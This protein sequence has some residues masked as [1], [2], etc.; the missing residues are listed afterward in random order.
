MNVQD[1]EQFADIVE[2]M[3]GAPAF[4]FHDEQDMHAFALALGALGTEVEKQA[5]A[6]AAITSLDQV[7]LY[8]VGKPVPKGR[9][10]LWDQATLKDLTGPPSIGS[11]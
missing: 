3:E 2:A 11:G 8:V 6:L 10:E 7:P 1:F 9:V 5:R 4:V